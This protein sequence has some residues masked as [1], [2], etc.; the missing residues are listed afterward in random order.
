M[1]VGTKE[2]GTAVGESILWHREL[3]SEDVSGVEIISSLAWLIQEIM[4]LW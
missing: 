2:S 4:N 3:A 1:D